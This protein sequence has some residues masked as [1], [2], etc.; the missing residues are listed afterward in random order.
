[1]DINLPD[2]VLGVGSLGT[3]SFALVDATK[4]FW[5]GVSNR[6]FGFI[7]RML[8][9]LVPAGHPQSNAD[10]AVSIESI[11]ATLRSNWI[12]GTASLSDQKSI[13]KTL[14]KLLLTQSTALHF[15]KTT[16][17]DPDLLKGVAAK[18]AN[19][20][21]LTPEEQNVAGRFDVELSAI[22]D[23][24]YQR[25]DQAYRNSSK[26]L[27][28]AIAVTLALAGKLSL[29]DTQITWGVAILAGILAAPL[30]PV[31]KDLASA[32]QAGVKTLQILRK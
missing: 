19:G 30:A 24:S 27:A 23:D 7:K 12:N 32:L 17:V 13:A 31:S 8:A 4:A 5:G 29:P 22:I 2:A 25:A 14:I 16:G 15:A 28:A 20:A 11:R 10:S 1:M 3:A 18:Y 26:L 9:R 21:A 6:G